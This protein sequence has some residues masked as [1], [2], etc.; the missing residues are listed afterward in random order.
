M[1]LL[2]NKFKKNYST[3]KRNSTKKI[4]KNLLQKKLSLR[5]K[6]L[7]LAVFI[8][9]TLNVNITRNKYTMLY[10]VCLYNNYLKFSFYLPSNY[11]VVEISKETNVIAL[12]SMAY[13]NFVKRYINL[14]AT[15]LNIFFKVN[16]K[17]LKFKGKGY[18]IY[19]NSRNTIAPQ[20]GYSHRLYIYSW[21][22]SLKFSSKTT[23]LLFGFISENLQAAAIRLKSFRSINVFTGRGVRFSRQC[24]YRKP[25]KISTY[26]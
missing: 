5:K 2:N 18:Y 6:S 1:L 16:F 22:N 19:K 11:F 24:I 23:L 7:S 20:F 15:T 14:I 25:G 3:T 8:P 17:K 9:F 4:K 26:R 10:N 13:S 21:F 12:A